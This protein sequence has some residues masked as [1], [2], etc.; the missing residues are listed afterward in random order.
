MLLCPSVQSLDPSEAHFVTDLC[1][2]SGPVSSCRLFDQT[3][4]DLWQMCKVFPGNFIFHHLNV[5]VL[6][7]KKSHLL[8]AGNTADIADTDTA[9]MTEMFD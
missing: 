9:D 5:C 6:Y 1:F 8:S 7:M 4:N 2:S 3:G